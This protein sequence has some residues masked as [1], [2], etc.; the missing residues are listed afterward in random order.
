M[1][2][3]QIFIRAKYDQVTMKVNGFYPSDVNYPNNV[4]DDDEKTIDGSPF[5]KITEEAHSENLGKNM[6]VEKGI[7][8]FKNN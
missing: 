4:I 5:L 2:K 6:I 7:F 3:E 8:L 1:K